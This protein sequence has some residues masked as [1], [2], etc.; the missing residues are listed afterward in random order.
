MLDS[1]CVFVYHTVAVLKKGHFSGAFMD[2]IFEK[3]LLYD[4]Y[5]ELLT[6]RQREIYENVVF[7]DMSLSEAAS[8][9]GVTRQGI[10]DMIRRSEEALKGYEERLHFLSQTEKIRK[11]AEEIKRLL[12][13]DEE[14][15]ERVNKLLELT[16]EILREL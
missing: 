5:G 11:N 8:E 15:G 2:R 13:R 12:Q 16:E 3:T 7:N 1:L 10:H 4:Y 9:Y 6:K 14:A